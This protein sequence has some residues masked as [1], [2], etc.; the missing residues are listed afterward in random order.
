MAE[1]LEKPMDSLQITNNEE[2]NGELKCEITFDNNENR[3]YFT[4]QTVT[5]CVRLI[6]NETITV[7]GNIEF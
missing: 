1:K 2:P 4:G 6:V 5:G 7:R 3:V